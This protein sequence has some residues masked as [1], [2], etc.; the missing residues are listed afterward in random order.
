MTSHEEFNNTEKTPPAKAE[1]LINL[2]PVVLCVLGV[3]VAVHLGLQFVS[4]VNQTWVQFAFAFIPARFGSLPF[5]QLPGSAYW[6]MITYGFLHADWVHLATNVVWLAIF[7]KP[8]ATW[9]G[10]K[11]Y[12]IIL[13]ASVVAGALTALAMH[14]GQNIAM[15]G[16]SAGVSGIMAAAIPIMYGVAE[17]GPGMP[18]GVFLRFRPLRPVELLQNRSALAFTILWLVLTM[19]TATSQYVT[20]TAFLEERSIAW[21]AHLGGFITGFVA[22]YAL[23]RKATSLPV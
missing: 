15:I 12:L 7:S 6:S 5:P 3:L 16:A 23:N 2:P 4:P 8:V 9:L 11:R 22:F 18:D 17:K 1:P 21:E 14:W 20:G 19:I 10:S 13:F